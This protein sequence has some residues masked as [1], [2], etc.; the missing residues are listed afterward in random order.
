MCIF[1][2]G[3]GFKTSTM[4]L[5]ADVIV[6]SRASHAGY[7]FSFLFFCRLKLDIYHIN[8][9][10]CKF[11]QIFFPY[12]LLIPCWLALPLILCCLLHLTSLSQYFL[13][14]CHIYLLAEQHRA[15]VFY[16]IHSCEELGRMMLLFQW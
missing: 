4:R 8:L 7:F 12:F 16:P 3:N 10:V 6:F 1:P 5:G 11:I 9:I 14:S 15:L 2:D 13:T